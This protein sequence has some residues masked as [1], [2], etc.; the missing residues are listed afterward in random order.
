[1]YTSNWNA[2]QL[3]DFR[4][5]LFECFTVEGYFKFTLT[6]KDSNGLAITFSADSVV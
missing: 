6:K 2:A 3:Q 5:Q 4:T 1:M